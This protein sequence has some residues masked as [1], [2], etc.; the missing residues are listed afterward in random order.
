MSTTT[1]STPTR[2]SAW[3][4]PPGAGARWQLVGSAATEP[5]CWALLWERCR[6]GDFAVTRDHRQPGYAPTGGYRRRR[7]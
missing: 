6:G 4:R 2:F 7:I 1:T 3:H 5:G